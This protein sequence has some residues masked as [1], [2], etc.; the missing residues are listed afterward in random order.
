[1]NK[2]NI[3][4][5]GAGSIANY[6]MKSYKMHSDKVCVKAVCDLNRERA[7]AF[8]N[9]YDIP[10][11]YTN[12]DEMLAE[13]ALDALS[14]ATWNNAHAPAAIAALNAGLHVLCE[15]PLAINACEAEKMLNAAKA[16]NRLL[17]VGFVRR[18]AQNTVA[19]KSIINS[20]DLGEIYSSKVSMIRRWGN[21]GG[22]FSDKK[23]SGGGALIDLGVHI[24]D[25]ARFLSGNPLPVSVYAATF[26]KLGIK[27]D[28][29]G[30]DKYRTVEQDDFC[31]VEDAATALI[32]F[33][34]GMVTYLN[35]TW[36]ENA[37]DETLIHFS[38]SKG[39]ANLE[40]SLEIYQDKYHYLCN[41]QPKLS[42]Q[43]ID[44]D[45]IFNKEI[46]HFIDCIQTGQACICPAEDGLW[47]MKILD[48][49]YESS[50]T[51]HEVSIQA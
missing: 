29:L 42:Y 9:T 3:A 39:G 40:P 7:Q 16:N 1:M 20:G 25:L 6:H 22:W 48:A 46:G 51:G 13:Q 21:P 27:P 36:V 23:R 34:N 12:F 18:F 19:L 2:T 41:T 8:A 5:I 50:R 10:N 44:M 37:D 49:I 17:M 15:K 38:G 24:I 32:R 35:V 4:I 33:D 26:S 28:I 31:D 45:D 43:G 14:V 11:V 30:V 47:L